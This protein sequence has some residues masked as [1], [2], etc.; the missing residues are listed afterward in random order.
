M[1]K[2]LYRVSNEGIIGGVCAGVARFLGVSPKLVRL[3]AVLFLFFGFFFITTVIYL[4]LMY[5]LE[6]APGHE[7]SLHGKKPFKS[8]LNNAEAELQTSKKRL[9]EIERF[10]TSNAYD[11]EKQFRNLK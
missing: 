9:N 11:I 8:V 4:I 7:A 3:I 1:S 2:K 10:V 6:D 5:V